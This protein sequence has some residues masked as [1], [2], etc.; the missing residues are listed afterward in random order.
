MEAG[1]EAVV[2]QFYGVKDIAIIMGMSKAAV[3][4]SIKAGKIPAIRVSHYPLI[5]R[6]WVEQQ[7]QAALASVGG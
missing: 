2:P 3:S 1:K 6:S 5:P 4:N 7:Q